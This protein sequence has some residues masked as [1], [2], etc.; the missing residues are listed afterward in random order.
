MKKGRK[1]C[2]GQMDPEH[3]KNTA[4][5]IN[6]AWLKRAKKKPKRRRRCGQDVL[7]DR[8]INKMKEIIEHPFKISITFCIKRN[9]ESI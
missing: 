1:N 4:Y 7:Y 3:S 6:Q 2:R 5:R 9:F 8:Q